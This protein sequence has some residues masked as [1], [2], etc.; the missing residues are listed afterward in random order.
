MKILSA[1][2][3]GLIAAV[4]VF[5]LALVVS[6]IKCIASGVSYNF[7][8]AIPI[9]MKGGAVIGSSIFVLTLIAPGRK[10]PKG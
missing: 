3:S 6:Y 5:A 9:A 1:A 7:S 2:L 4:S 8:I 10:R